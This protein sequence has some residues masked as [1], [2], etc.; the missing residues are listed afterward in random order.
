MATA[1]RRKAILDAAVPLLI[2]RGPAV[3]TSE[4]AQAAEIAEGTIFRVFPDKSALIFDAVEL[5]MDPAR[6][7]R[8]IKDIAAHKSFEARLADAARLLS[9][10]FNQVTAIGECLRALSLQGSVRHGDVGKMVKESSAIITAALTDFFSQHRAALRVPPSSA[11]AA[12][13]GL[14]FASVHPMLPPRDRLKTDEVAQILMSGI[15]LNRGE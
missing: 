15:A 7:A 3:T 12:F 8:G 10:Y 1:D 2:K 9:D 13:R 14:V 11:V 5:T 6:V 4:I